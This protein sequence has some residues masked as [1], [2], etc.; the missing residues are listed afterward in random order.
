MIIIHIFF[1]SN[2]QF[3]VRIYTKYV[4][5]NKQDNKTNIKPS[6]VDVVLT[7]YQWR[8]SHCSDECI[9]KGDFHDIVVAASIM[10]VHKLLSKQIVYKYFNEIKNIMRMILNM[11]PFNFDDE[12]DQ[13]W[14]HAILLDEI[15]DI[16]APQKRRTWN[17]K[18][19]PYLNDELTKV[20]NVLPLWTWLLSV[21][22]TWECPSGRTTHPLLY[23]II[24]SLLPSHIISSYLIMLILNTNHP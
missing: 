18:Q 9:G 7:N 1:H 16:H 24:S 21:S 3:N 4:Q 14:Y 20:I 22:K 15:I 6:P 23:H 10:F 11:H 17:E 13:L 12:H 8:I 19:F 2:W 5:F